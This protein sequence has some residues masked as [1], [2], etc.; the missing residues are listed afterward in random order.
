MFFSLPTERLTRF[1]FP[2]R[3]L[4]GIDAHQPDLY[5][6]VIPHRFN[7][8][9]IVN[10]NHLEKT[11]GRYGN[12]VKA[13]EVLLLFDDTSFGKADKGILLTNKNI[14]FSHS[15]GPQACDLKSIISVSNIGN[16]NLALLCDYYELQYFEFGSSNANR[17]E[18]LASLL[19]KISN[20]TW[21]QNNNKK[22]GG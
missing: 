11:G 15:E 21:P 3:S 1:A 9:A 2:F 19:N 8:I 18:Y 13:D 10:A 22:T 7:R 6:N 4:R 20:L 12:G 17:V 16:K 5:F 14:Y